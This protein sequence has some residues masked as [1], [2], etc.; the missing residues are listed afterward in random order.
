MC[1]AISTSSTWQHGRALRLAGQ[2]AEAAKFLRRAVAAEPNDNRLHDELGMALSELGRYEEAIGAFLAAYQLN[3]DSDEACSKI[4][5]SF[6]ARGMFEPAVQWFCRAR[7]LNPA[8]SD[9]LYPYGRALVSTNSLELAAEVFKDWLKKEPENPIARHLAAAALGTRGMKQA[10]AEY[11]VGLFDSCAEKFDENLGRLN[12]RGPELVLDALRQTSETPAQGWRIVDVGCG[13][14]L[15][16]AVL[17]PLANRLIGVDLSP[18][19]LALAQ[20]RSIYDEL[21][22]ADITEYLKGHEYSFDVLAAADVLTYVGDLD[23][24][25]HAAA[26]SLRLGGLV[27]ALLE[28][29]DGD[30][31]YRLNLSGRFSHSS[32]YL[33]HAMESAGFRVDGIRQDSM[34]N[35]SGRAVKTLVA[36]GRRGPV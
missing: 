2:A 34:R 16:G 15:V 27:V 13:T 23:D 19:M 14:G 32:R 1:S 3:P 29:L 11:V 24:F 30:G 33:R 26:S 31:T 22:Q 17:R 8:G 28:A 25:F 9:Y 35:E 4:G 36:T 18:G 20:S 10:S 6:A 21:V 7:Q 12:Y 5:S